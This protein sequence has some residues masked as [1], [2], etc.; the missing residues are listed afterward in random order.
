[1]KNNWDLIDYEAVKDIK[2]RVSLYYVVIFL[3]MIGI[4][5]I[6]FKFNFQTFS[7]Q[8]LIKENN[9]FSL[10]VDSREITFLENNHSIYIN[11]NKYKYKILDISNEYTNINNAIYQNVS[12]MLYNYKTDAIMTE[13]YFLKDSKTFTKGIIEF[14]EGGKK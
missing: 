4:I 12:I 1:M 2:Y 5:F 9:S 6:M 8:T 11:G 3:V 13:C 14:I 7:K 10:I